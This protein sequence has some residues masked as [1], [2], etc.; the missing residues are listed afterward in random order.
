MFNQDQWGYQQRTLD[1]VKLGPIGI[2]TRNF[3]LYS[4]RTVGI[5]IGSIRLCSTRSSM[6]ISQ[7]LLNMFN[8]DRLVYQQGTLYYVQP[9]LIGIST[10]NFRLC[11]IRTDGIYRQGTLDYVHSRLIGISTENFRLC[12]TSTEGYVDKELQIIFNQHCRQEHQNMFD[13]DGQQYRQRTLDYVQPGS[14]LDYVQPQLIWISVGNIR[15]CSTRTDRYIDKELYIMLKQDQ[16]GHQHGTSNFETYTFRRKHNISR[17]PFLFIECLVK[18]FS[19][20][21]LLRKKCN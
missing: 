4:T 8:K 19:T 16:Q 2:S 15:L 3:R 12:S 21:T 20:K 1:Y 11:S 5:S 17:M 13:Q 7:E 18:T 14:I 10:G 9:G 6:Y